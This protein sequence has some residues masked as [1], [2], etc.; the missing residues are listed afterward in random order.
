MFPALRDVHSL[1]NNTGAVSCL[2]LFKFK[3]IKV[4]LSSSS[5]ALAT[6]EV[7]SSHIPKMTVQLWDFPSP[8]PMEESSSRSTGPEPCLYPP[9]AQ[10]GPTGDRVASTVFHYSTGTCG[11]QGIELNQTNYPTENSFA[12]L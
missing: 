5:V 9:E 6:F 8:P 11:Q 1:P 2:W 7:L 12:R 3:L 10:D 4:K